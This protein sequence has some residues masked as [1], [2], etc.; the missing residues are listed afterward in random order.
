MKG[1]AHG[2]AMDKFHA[3]SIADAFK[4]VVK[5]ASS[6]CACADAGREIGFPTFFYCGQEGIASG[7]FVADVDGQRVALALDIECAL[8]YL[9]GNDLCKRALHGALPC[10]E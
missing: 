10:D 2:A 9:T 3:Y 1:T 8:A 6:Y 7:L 5:P 4:R